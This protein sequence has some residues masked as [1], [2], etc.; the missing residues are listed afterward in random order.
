MNIKRK[1]IITNLPS[2]YKIELYNRIAKQ[3]DILVI[4]TGEK[5]NDR[6]KDFFHGSMR[7]DS[8]FLE[9]TT[10][11][12]VGQLFGILCKNYYQELIVSGWDSLFVWL[13]VG[14]SPKHKNSV[15]VES[16]I[17][18]SVLT[19]VKGWLKRLFVK[20]ISKA[21]VSGTPHAQLMRALNFK[22]DIVI[23]KGVGIFH[24]HPQPLFVPRSEVRK[25]LYV[26]RLVPVKNLEFLIEKF[27]QHPELELTVIGFGILEN[28]LKSIAK[29]NIHFLGAVDNEKLP[30]YYQNADI[31]ILP[32]LSEPWGLVVEEALNNGTPVMVSEQ[33]G[34]AEDLVN[35]NTGVVF[36][37]KKNDFDTKLNEIRDINRY[38]SMRRFISTLD[39][40]KIEQEQVN[41]YL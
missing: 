15:V 25:F 4:Y 7:F 26:G 32:S 17:K 22:R 39:Y 11:K 9:G 24:Y 40:E 28:K 8:L 35:E 38:N 37:L 5:G 41:C 21:Y 12:K 20:R 16:S 19:G 29:D 1:L 10:I 14:I 27:N 13:A 23:T 18:E 34:C 2:F 33:V 3:Q 30:T 31:F 6:N 36:S